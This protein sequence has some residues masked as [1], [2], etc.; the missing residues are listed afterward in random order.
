MGKKAIGAK[1]NVPGVGKGLVESHPRKIKGEEV[2]D[3]RIGD[4]KVIR[5][6]TDK[7]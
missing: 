7:L 5:V 3:V 6:P 2:Q 4:H 1:V